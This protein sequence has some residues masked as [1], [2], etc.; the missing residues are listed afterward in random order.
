MASLHLNDFIRAG[1]DIEGAQYRIRAKIQEAHKAFSASHIYPHLGELVD[2]YTSLQAILGQLKGL[3]DSIPKKIK[4]IDLEDQAIVYERQRMDDGQLSYIEELVEWA[5]P[6]VQAAIEEGKTIYEFVED[7]IHLQEV[8]IVPSYIEEGYLMIPDRAADL[9]Y[10]LQY[11]LSIVT[12][13]TE[14]FRTLRTTHIKTLPHGGE[15]ITPQKAKLD[16]L[17]AKR[18]LPNPATYVLN[19]ELSF[20]YEPTMLPVGK[21]KLMRYLSQQ[22]GVA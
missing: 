3:R 20:P 7:N 15:K 2:L 4:D 6:Y 19:T 17:E 12:G 13:S 1:Q 21:R 14:R 18:D 11:N 16:L 8:G 5:L 10:V 22:G 9:M